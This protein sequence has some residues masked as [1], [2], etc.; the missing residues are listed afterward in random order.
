[1]S[2]LKHDFNDCTVKCFMPASPALRTVCPPYF[3]TVAKFCTV[4]QINSWLKGHWSFEF[5]FKNT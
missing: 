3:V 1:M 4:F 2:A 5:Q